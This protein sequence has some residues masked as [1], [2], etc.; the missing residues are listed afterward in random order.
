MTEIKPSVFNV[1]DLIEK[2]FPPDAYWIEP[3]IPKRSIILIGGHAKIGKSFTMGN[4]CHAAVMGGDLFPPEP[5]YP[6]L[7]LPIGWRTPTATKPF[8]VLFIDKEL[9]ERTMRKRVLSIM[10]ADLDADRDGTLQ[11]IRENYFY[12]SKDSGGV[13]EP[14]ITLSNKDG[15]VALSKLCEQVKP[16][17]LI[18]DPA[19]KMHHYDENS[20]DQIQR[21]YDD[22]ESLQT[23][24]KDTDMSIIVTHHFGKPQKMNGQV[25][26]NPLDPYNFRG[27]SKWFDLPDGLMMMAR[28]PSQRPGQ[29]G[30]DLEM[31]FK[32]RH[33]AEMPKMVLGVNQLGDNRI[34]TRMVL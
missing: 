2:Q 18:I 22:L 25:V 28:R 8:R 13:D 29:L 5:N 21:F 14:K 6:S 17:L 30:W 3:F 27:S 31:E 4:I 16:N 24:N 11:K 20:A 34:Y 10:Q 26:G 33:D 1:A 7:R 12:H 32:P 15:K 19:G 9:G 23:E